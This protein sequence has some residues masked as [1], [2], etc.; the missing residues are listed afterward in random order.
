MTAEWSFDHLLRY[1]N[2]WS[3]TRAF[4]KDKGENPVEL[5]S[6]KLKVAW[7]DKANLK[8]SWPLVLYVG[9]R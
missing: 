5:W 1:L 2:T 7:G 8:V 3:A 4:E 9:R 6:E